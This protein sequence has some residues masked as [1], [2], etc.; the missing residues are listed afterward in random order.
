M[1]D[2][3]KQRMPGDSRRRFRPFSLRVCDYQDGRCRRGD[4]SLPMPLGANGLAVAC[5][6][7]VNRSWR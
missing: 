2:I 6:A 4:D 5:A 3:D 7:R 1:H